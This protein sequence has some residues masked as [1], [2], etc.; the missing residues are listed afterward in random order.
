ME[1]GKWDRE[2]IASLKQFR[3]LCILKQLKGTT[4]LPSSGNRSYSA[5]AETLQTRFH[6]S[7]LV[8]LFRHKCLLQIFWLLND[9]PYGCYKSRYCINSWSLRTNSELLAKKKKGKK[10]LWLDFY[11]KYDIHLIA[12]HKILLLYSI[13]CQYHQ[14]LHCLHSFHFLFQVQEC[15]LL[16][17]M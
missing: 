6:N 4:D 15:V 17:T 10:N 1:Q 9:E 5:A 16:F 8:L 11:I 7:E 13:K 12:V 14:V 3:E 2:R